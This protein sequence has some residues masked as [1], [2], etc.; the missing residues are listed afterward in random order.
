VESLEGK[1]KSRSLTVAAGR[2]PAAQS[3]ADQTQPEPDRSVVFDHPHL[4]IYASSTAHMLALKARAARA[5]DLRDLRLLATDL[6][7]TTADEVFH[8]VDRFFPDNPMGAKAKAV[9]E[10]LFG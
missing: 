1:P 8:V 7:V 5:Q 6:G 10:D 2:L 4:V 9:I 3:G